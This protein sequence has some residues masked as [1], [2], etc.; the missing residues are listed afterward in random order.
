MYRFLVV[1]TIILVVIII[2]FIENVY[3]NRK[4]KHTFKIPDESMLLE[5]GNDRIFVYNND[6][7]KL[8]S[9]QEF[10]KLYPKGLIY[11]IQPK[12]L[13]ATKINVPFK[14]FINGLG[15]I[16]SETP[17][18]GVVETTLPFIN[19]MNNIILPTQNKFGVLSDNPK[20]NVLTN[21]EYVFIS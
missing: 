9:K 1:L 18:T 17:V 14:R 13:L 20:I 6:Y 7:K 12:K 5:I 2:S 19:D 11:E 21:D 15:N 16:N 8:F 4:I 3:F 10:G